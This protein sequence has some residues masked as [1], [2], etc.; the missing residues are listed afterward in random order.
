MKGDEGDVDAA[1]G[2]SCRVYVNKHKSSRPVI[3]AMSDTCL[4]NDD[5]GKIA[6]QNQLP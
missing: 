5:T 4:S 3:S 6:S 2:E 1:T